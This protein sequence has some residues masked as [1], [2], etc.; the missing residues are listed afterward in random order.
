[1]VSPHT[2]PTPSVSP[3][4]S[5]NKL[6]FNETPKPPTKK[7]KIEKIEKTQSVS[8]RQEKK[9]KEKDP[10]NYP[11]QPN[12]PKSSN[13]LSK[14]PSQSTL[15]SKSNLRNTNNPKHNRQTSVDLV[16]EK[17]NKCIENMESHIKNYFDQPNTK[18]E[19]KELTESINSNFDKINNNLA[20]S[21]ESLNTS[22]ISNVFEKNRM[23]LNSHRDIRKDVSFEKER[24]CSQQR[25]EVTNLL[26]E[27]P[28]F[29][30]M[31]E[32]GMIKGFVICD[33][34]QMRVGIYIYIFYF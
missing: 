31:E 16:V 15:P 33:Y 13:Q 9:D 23:N 26:E 32:K 12:K 2:D 18:N 27:T 1:M 8:P 7:E 6:K 3:N 25:Y 20:I 21:K 34:N 29:Y 22:N 4:S 17:K 11:F 19:L 10:Y 5:R 30:D 14:S 24:G 28:Q